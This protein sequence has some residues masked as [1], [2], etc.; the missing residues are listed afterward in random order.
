MEDNTQRMR[1]QLQ[2]LITKGKL[3]NKA[4]FFMGGI[5]L[6]YEVSRVLKD[7]RMEISGVLDNN[8][9]K[10]GGAAYKEFSCQV[11]APEKLKQL[12]RGG[13]L[14]LI[15]SVKYWLEMKE[16]MEELGYRQN[17][18]FIILDV[19][20]LQACIRMNRKAQ[21]LFRGLRGQYGKNATF[22]LLNSVMGDCYLS[23]LCMRE[24]I[25]ENN[26]AN[27]VLLG[28]GVCEKIVNLFDGYQ[29]VRIDRESR[30]AIEAYWAFAGEKKSHLKILS[31]WDFELHFNRCRIRFAEAFH[32]M[33]TYTAFVFHLK[34]KKFD[35]PEF[36]CE[37]L[38]DL[39]AEKSLQ[40][41]KTVVLSPYAYSILQQ[42]PAVFWQELADYLREKGYSVCVN[43]NPERE[44]NPVSDAPDMTFTLKE[45][46]PV[47]EYA[48]TLI[49]MRSGFCDVTSSADCRK[50]LF[51]P[52]RKGGID[53]ENH[54]PDK[55]F[56]GLVN[57]G[58]T[59]QAT[60]LEFDYD[61][62]TWQVKWE[63]LLKEVK[64][65]L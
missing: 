61:P 12:K 22:I 39:F 41:G 53:Y 2:C 3:K 55:D 7:S 4:I 14:L 62:S 47:L 9:Q 31:I 33:D 11:Y 38:N 6:A 20:D 42:P 56:G 13:F 26:I 58:L 57:M 8:P 63:E 64:Q 15:Y 17:R 1:E 48:G 52:M 51:Y 25:A 28:W 16:Q 46:V 23:M 32:F 36:Y 60:E 40:P 24:Y 49:A 43:I 18:D 27:P 45:S 54:R 44:V 5:P 50:I 65:I 59:T 29:F 19:Y 30:I 21:K 10:W 35:K 37:N 34:E